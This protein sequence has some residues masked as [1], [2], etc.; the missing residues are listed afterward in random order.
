M[1]VSAM[2]ATGSYVPEICIRNEDLTQFPKAARALIEQKT[3]ILERRYA[4]DGASTSD[5]AAEAARR[6]LEQAGLDAAAV[7]AL[8][9]STSSPDRIQ[10]A[11]A[12]RV[13]ALIGACRAIAFDVNAVCT[14]ALY[15]LQIA[16]GF[17]RGGLY[18]TVLVV[19]AEAYS[20]FLNRSDFSTCPYFGD[21]AGALLL[22]ASQGPPSILH[23]LLRT[24]GSCWDVIGIPG[25]G[26]MLPC[27]RITNPGDAYFSMH[28]REV[29]DFAVQRG[30]EIVRQLL[31]SSG[32]SARDIAAV[33]AHQANLN[34]LRE[35]AD[36]TGIPFSKFP[37]TLERYGNTASASILI[38][39][40]EAIRSGFLVRG[41]L[42][43]LVA[44]GGGLS[45]GSSLIQL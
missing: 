12:A 29:F 39:L 7:D 21:G 13:Q 45:W 6:C 32:I 20:R 44:F 30:A 11:T 43:V 16:E 25:G 23:T 40:D 3:G 4:P 8:V 36:R 28:G 17:I 15:C 22:R 37:L 24:D 14:G 33:V 41:D 2:I 35:I 9:L 38:T 27:H 5:L 34:V 26:A 31:D 42:T 19:A 1:P 18:R 10:P